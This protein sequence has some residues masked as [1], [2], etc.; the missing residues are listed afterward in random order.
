VPIDST[1]DTFDIAERTTGREF[2]IFAS[3]DPIHPLYLSSGDADGSRLRALRLAGGQYLLS[4]TVGA[5]PSVVSLSYLERL[6]NAA[7][8]P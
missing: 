5:A 8:T 6:G 1:A 7:G 2:A 3:T 4:I